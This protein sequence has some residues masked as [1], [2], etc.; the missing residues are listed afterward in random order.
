MSVINRCLAFSPDGEKLAAGSGSGPSSLSLHQ[1]SDGSQIWTKTVHAHSIDAI[2]FSTDGST[3]AT[4]ASYHDYSGA[5]PQDPTVKL[6]AVSNGQWI[7]AINK[8]DWNIH[9]V[10]FAFDGNTLAAGGLRTS[11]RSGHRR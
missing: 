2:A 8:I 10:A 11:Y 4:G 3:I 5:G 1:A 9:A 7:R 6:W